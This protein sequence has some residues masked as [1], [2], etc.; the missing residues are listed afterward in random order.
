L[1]QRLCYLRVQAEPDHE[2]LGWLDRRLD[3]VRNGSAPA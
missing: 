1:R 2:F 3:G